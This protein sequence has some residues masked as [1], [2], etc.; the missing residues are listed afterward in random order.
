MCLLIHQ[1]KGVTFSTAELQDFIAYNPD[2]FGLAYGDRKQLHSVRMVGT[3]A[4]IITTYRQIAAGRECILHFRMKTHGATNADN[5]HPFPVTPDIVMAHNGILSIGNPAAPQMS[6]TWHLV[7]YFI[8]PIAEHSP[9]L[10]FCPT[11]GKMLGEMIGNGNKLAFA[12]RDG[13]IAVI[14]RDEGVEHKGAWLS[15]TYA[16]SSPENTRWTY[17]KKSPRALVAGWDVDPDDAEVVPDY[18]AEEILDEAL[19]SYVD[20]AEQ[21]VADW[22]RNNP[23]E[24]AI[25]LAYTH[26]I[27]EDEAVAW[28]QDGNAEAATALAEIIADEAPAYSYH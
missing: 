7:E 18:I 1:P 28:L 26:G 27:D 22:C 15:N 9:E 13:R 14:N 24:A 20:Y 2:G 16:W 8:R 21:G 23:A 17:G 11:W 12:H 10:L 19:Q 25:A 5:A 4:E 3:A 6:D